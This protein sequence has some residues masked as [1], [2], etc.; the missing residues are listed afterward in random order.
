MHIDDLWL[1]FLTNTT[2]QTGHRHDLE[3]IWL[4][5]LGANADTLNDAW[6]EVFDL[7]GVEPGQFNDR[8]F[9]WLSLQGATGDQ[10][11]DRLYNWLAD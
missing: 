3:L 8:L 5:G 7:D 1:S 11:N 10:L 6:G 9:S 4:K 2:G